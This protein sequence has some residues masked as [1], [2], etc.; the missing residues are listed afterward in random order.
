VLTAC[1]VGLGGVSRQN[2][3]FKIREIRLR[4]VVV[5]LIFL[6]AG[7]ALTF[8]LRG[9]VSRRFASGGS[10]FRGD[11][12][13]CIGD[14]VGMIT[15]VP[16]VT[17]LFAFLSMPTWK[18]PSYILVSCSVFTLGTCLAFA[19]IFAALRARSFSGDHKPWQRHWRFLV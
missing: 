8:P 12:S 19:A 10:V 18:W 9:A 4:D 6:P 17:A 11:A 3:N 2:L 13:L 14:A 15:V 7:A 5:L 16:T 1:Y